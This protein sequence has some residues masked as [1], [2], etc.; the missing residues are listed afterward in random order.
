MTECCLKNWNVLQE[1]DGHLAIAVPQPLGFG[2]PAPMSEGI[3][4]LSKKY[5]SMAEESHF[6]L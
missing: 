2:D 1:V 5:T 4:P 3:D 6:T